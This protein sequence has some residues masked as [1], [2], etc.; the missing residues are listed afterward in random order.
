LHLL[1]EESI[2]KTLEKF[3]DPDKI[4]DKNIAF[5]REKGL[6]YMKNLLKSCL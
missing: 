6:D 4:P 2:E 5:A 3:P 1:K